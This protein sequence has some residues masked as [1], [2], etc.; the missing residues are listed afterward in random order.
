[1]ADFHVIASTAEKVIVWHDRRE[2]S[3][4]KNG[5]K[6]LWSLPE[7]DVNLSSYNV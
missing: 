5:S 4:G 3:L 1:M 6:L 7:N 2:T